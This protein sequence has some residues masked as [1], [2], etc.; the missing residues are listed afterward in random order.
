MWIVFSSFLFLFV[1][2]PSSSSLLWGV[3]QSDTKGAQIPDLD[4]IDTTF[5]VRKE[6]LHLSFIP[7]YLIREI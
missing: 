3:G 5:F 6:G 1:L 4:K 7:R 2:F